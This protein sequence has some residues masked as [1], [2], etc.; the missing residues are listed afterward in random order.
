[1]LNVRK[2]SRIS[3]KHPLP[4]PR[5]DDVNEDRKGLM[6]SKDKEKQKKTELYLFYYAILVSFTATV[7]SVNM[8]SGKIPFI[9]FPLS[10]KV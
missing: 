10:R 4:L 9:S 3:S 8:K 1:M 5:L 2:A 7:M 6:H